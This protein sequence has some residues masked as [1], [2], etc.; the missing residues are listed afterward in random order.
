MPRMVYRV[1]PNGEQWVVTREGLTLST[2]TSRTPAVALGQAIAKANQP[3]QLVVVEPDS[4]RE[5]EYTYGDDPPQDDASVAA[6][7][8]G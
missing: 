5:R 4:G 7:C 6:G 1:L 8:T 3:S 2:H